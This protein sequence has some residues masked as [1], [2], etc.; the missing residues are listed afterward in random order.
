MTPA[1]ATPGNP[2]GQAFERGG[3]K[4]HRGASRPVSGSLQLPTIGTGALF[5]H[6]SDPANKQMV[7]ENGGDAPCSVD[8]EA[9]ERRRQHGKLRRTLQPVAATS[10]GAAS[11]QAASKP[12]DV[13]VDPFAREGAFS[14]CK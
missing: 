2:F 10:T 7:V 3:T 1:A 9:Q 4:I 5:F 8:V 6:F 13:R 14:G 12:S 11:Q